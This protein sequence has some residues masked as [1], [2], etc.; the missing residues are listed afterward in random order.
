MAFNSLEP[1][2]SLNLIIILNCSEFIIK[3]FAK[4]YRQYCFLFDIFWDDIAV[5]GQLTHTI[6]EPITHFPV[7][8]IDYIDYPESSI[9]GDYSVDR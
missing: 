4:E 3:L 6:T 2:K 9:R 5:R 7:L 8:I 1:L